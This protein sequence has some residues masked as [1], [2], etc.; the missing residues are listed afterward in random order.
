M[1]FY[2]SP[3]Y[4]CPYLPGQTAQTQIWASFHSQTTQSHHVPMSTYGAL[5]QAGFRRS[6]DQVYRPQCPQCQA[7]VPLRLIVDRFQATRAQ[8]RAWAAHQDLQA[9]V[10]PLTVQAQ[11]YALYRAYQGAR[12]ARSPMAEDSMADYESFIM[13]SPVDSCLVRFQEAWPHSKRERERE[14]QAQDHALRMV[15]VIDILPDGLSAV[16]TF[17]DPAPSHS[18][19]TFGILWQIEYAR[20]LGLPF[21]YL[22]YWIKENP[23]MAYKAR[24]HAHEIFINGRWETTHPPG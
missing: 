20:Q 15:S 5:T 17:Y 24:F 16:Y 13:E 10:G 2:L 11:D 14:T 9:H 1:P 4:P 18:Y 19:G 12:H 6:G 22:G 7:C 21:V 8:R 3:T 23:Q